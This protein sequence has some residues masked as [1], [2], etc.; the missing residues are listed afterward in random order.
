MAPPGLE[1]QV[2]SCARKQELQASGKLAIEK[3]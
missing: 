1:W 3:K 2:F